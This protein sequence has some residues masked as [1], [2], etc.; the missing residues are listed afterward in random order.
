VSWS[1]RRSLTGLAIAG[2][3][4]AAAFP[5]SLYYIGLAIG[6]SRPMPARQ[7]VPPLLANAIWA[8]AGGGRAAE[9]TPITPLS[10]L[11]LA[12]CVAN[13]DFWDT[14]P[15]DARR[16]AA[17]RG[18]MPALEGLEYFANVHMR[19]ADYTPGFRT[20][21]SRFSTSVWVTH[22]WTKTEFLN[23]LAERAEFSFRVRG[24]DHA[25]RALFDRSASELDLPQ[26]ALTAAMIGDRRVDPW[27]NPEAAANMRR[28][29]L[30]RMLEDGAIDEAAYQS[31]NMA[32]LGLVPPP[33]MHTPC[34]A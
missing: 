14:T 6:P 12:A 29:V 22:A 16:V 11:R 33:G 9:L 34:E 27:C 24:V 23:A 8:R 10:M 1:A 13:E 5:F 21:L 25:A 26:A 31:A 2:L 17:C 20:G 3:L 19:D 15:G 30:E 32:D 7:P 18:H 4:G 28:R